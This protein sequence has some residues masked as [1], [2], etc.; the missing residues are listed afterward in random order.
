MINMNEY[1]N[2]SPLRAKSGSNTLLHC[3]SLSAVY[4]LLRPKS[5]FMR[6]LVKTGILT[7]I[8]VFM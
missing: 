2:A 7:H 1:W 4:S 8:S 5:L 3:V 6:I